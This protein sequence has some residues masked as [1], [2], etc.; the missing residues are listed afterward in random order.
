MTFQRNNKLGRGRPP[1][2]KSLSEALRLEM[3]QK[4]PDGRTK[5]RAVAEKLVARALEG[6][7]SAIREVFD[8]VEGKAL[9]AEMV[10]APRPIVIEILPIDELTL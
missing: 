4:L 2:G 5:Y 10:D 7:L 8:R 3:T 1:A 9:P 6:E